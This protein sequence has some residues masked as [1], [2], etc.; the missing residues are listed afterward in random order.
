MLHYLKKMFA[1]LW[2]QILLRVI[3]LYTQKNNNTKQIQQDHA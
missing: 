3:S 2:N 1:I